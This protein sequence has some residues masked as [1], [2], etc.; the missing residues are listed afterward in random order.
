M[1][2]NTV[3]YRST[4]KEAQHPG[5]AALTMYPCYQRNTPG[6]AEEG[7]IFRGIRPDRLW[8]FLN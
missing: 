1:M 2:Q 6:S 4:H 3:R 7:L 8:V 5:G